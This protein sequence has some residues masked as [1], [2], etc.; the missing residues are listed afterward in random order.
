[1]LSVQLLGPVEVRIDDVL[2][3]LGGPQ[4]RAVIAHL[5]LEPGHVVSVERLID[6][7]WGDEP[8]RTPLGTLQSYVSRLRRALEPRRAAGAPAEVLVSEAPGYLLRVEPTQVDIHRFRS[9]VDEARVAAGAGDHARALARLDAALGL[10]RGP[11]LAGI[12]AD[13]LVRPVVV[14]L[15]E[16]RAAALDERF[17]ALLALGRHQ[18]AIPQLQAA[19]DEQPMHERLWGLLALAF[20][21]SGR[22]ADALR[23]V[24]S[25][26]DVLLDELGLDPGP[27]L[28]DLEHRI[29]AQD[30][31][32]LLDGGVQ[33]P[34]AAAPS[35]VPVDAPRIAL[36]GRPAEWSA[37]Q[38]S[39]DAA[40]AVPG[41]VL[42]EGEPGIGKSTLCDAFLAHARSVGWH[43]VTGRCLEPGLAPTLWPCIEIA[44]AL[45]TSDGVDVSDHDDAGVRA[46]NAN[47]WQRLAAGR[48]V[49]TATVELADHFVDLLHAAVE[50]PGSSGCVVLVDDLHWADQATLD[51]VQL[52]LSRLGRGGVLV[53]AA[54]R[55]PELFPD[56]LL[57]AA[58]S[59]LHRSVAAATRVPMAPLDTPGVAELIAATTGVAPSAELAERVQTRTSGNPLFVTELARLAGERGI[60]DASIVPDAVRDVVRS[61]LAA[62]PVQA[63]AELEVAAVVGER[64]DVRTV[65]AASERDPDSCLDALDAAIV[66]RIL[67]PE[68]NGYRFAHALVRDAVLADLPALRSA[69]LHR[70]VADAILAV[71]GDVADAAEPVAH[72]RYAAR[73][74]VDPVVV[75]QA[76]VRASDVARWRNALDTAERWADLALDVLDGAPRA[77]EAARVEVARVEV[78][79]LEALLGMVARRGDP[80]RVEALAARVRARGESSDN[81]GARALGLFLVW[82]DVDT[83]GDLA[84]PDLMAG[85]EQARRLASRTSDPY[86]LLTCHY[87]IGAHAMLCG[88]LDDAAEHLDLALGGERD[89][90]AEVTPQHVPVV[91]LPVVAAITAAV[92]GDAESARRH[93][94][95]R[96]RAWLAQRAEVDDAVQSALAFTSALTEALLGEPQ[97]LLERIPGGSRTG[98]YGFLDG[99]AAATDVLRLWALVMVGATERQSTD[100]EAGSLAESMLASMGA[101][102]AGGEHS[103]R[104]ALWTFVA[105]ALV[106]LGDERAWDALDR[107]AEEATS[108]GEYV[109]YAET[110]RVRALADRRLGDGS[111]VGA[112]LDEA[113]ARAL[114]SGA[115]GIVPRVRSTRE[116][117]DGQASR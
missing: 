38:R 80:A 81:D 40:V 78:E 65:M 15:E 93:G 3:D 6:R 109:W 10:W 53:V 2:V 39:L 47:P 77:S 99:Q 55:P 49:A 33:R 30:P 96:I 102:E 103:L 86:A 68:A 92:R 105:H 13:D 59:G 8:P 50:R 46:P 76:L 12:G 72:H 43:T 24:S 112:L 88:R 21:R 101:F 100:P 115:A 62:L 52:V 42:L 106:E 54:H 7:L 61:R 117:D 82:D 28:R 98:G 32:L 23:A 51:V 22:Q 31:G 60:D 73:S 14:R 37:L 83:I 16:E 70:R 17:E 57:A 27:E 74:F 63:I 75:A 110:L 34:A 35:P 114:A 66:T 95:V 9:L 41:L 29:L 58:L 67:V 56:S 111:N 45:L 64:F 71:Q 87:M 94:H 104:S 26:R 5:A 84:D 89:R 69:R 108:R 113:E 36:V 25:A 48:Q 97:H 85:L 90:P 11:A 79:V 116:R 4:Q 107:A 20:Y 91:L 1:M 44:R 18:E 19:V